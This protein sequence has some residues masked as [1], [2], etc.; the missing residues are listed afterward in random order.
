MTRR[1][2]RA[3]LLRSATA[4][5][6][7][8]T[9]GG[10]LVATAGAAR[11][12][13]ASSPGLAV[14]LGGW[15]LVDGVRVVKGFDPTWS[16]DG[17]RLAFLRDGHVLVVD[18][19]GRRERRL[20][21]RAPGLHWPASGPAWSPDGR[22]IAFSGTRDLF[23]VPA[24]GGTLV[25]LTRSS[26]SWR[27]NATPAFRP[28]G[29]V[30]AFSRSTDA[31]NAD[32]FTIS[33]DGKR[34]RRLT[35]TRGTHGALGEET[36]PSW[37]PDGRTLVYVSNRDGNF[38]L[39]AIGADGRNERRLTRTPGLDEERPRFARDGRSLLY[40]REGRVVVSDV[41]GRHPRVLGSGAAADRR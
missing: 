21:R 41:D 20:T 26:E 12:P 6:L 10:L 34:L 36:M 22:R 28:D 14:Q 33:V 3:R 17:R 32:I 16:P 37:S 19:D 30:I 24:A 31:F 23:L 5:A 13:G 29:K 11:Q 2:T 8:A 18:A 1:D 27:L 40:V 38:E 39:Y 9:A 15:V 7:L 25:P 35:T 4:L